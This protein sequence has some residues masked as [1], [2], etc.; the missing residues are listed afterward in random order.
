MVSIELSLRKLAPPI[1][2]KVMRDYSKI[3]SQNFTE[4]YTTPYYSHNTTLDEAYH[5]FQEDLLKA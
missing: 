5:L 4:N 2:R 3:T 1:V